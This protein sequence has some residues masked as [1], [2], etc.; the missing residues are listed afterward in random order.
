MNSLKNLI[1]ILLFF[2]VETTFAAT[3]TKPT[4]TYDLGASTGTYNGYGYTEINL[5]LNWNLYDYLTWR[6]SFFSR[7]VQSLSSVSGLDSSARFSWDVTTEGG[8]LGL[9]VFAGPGVRFSKKEN[10]ATFVEA[11]LTVKLGGI[12]IGGGFKTLFYNS[13]GTDS[14][15]RDLPKSDTGYFIV[16]SGGGAF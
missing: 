4:L 12:N 2:L 14:S 13:P 10:S 16:L 8:G 6:N 9:G 1:L 11:G 5:G 3:S 15:G 7:S